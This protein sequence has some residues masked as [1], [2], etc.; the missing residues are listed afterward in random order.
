MPTTKPQVKT[1]T[2][3]E[4]VK[5]FSIIAEKESRSVS[6]ELEYIIKQKIIDYEK[7]HGEI[8]C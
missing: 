7:E 5:K 1:Y 4:T 6:K 2:D 3:T 8:K